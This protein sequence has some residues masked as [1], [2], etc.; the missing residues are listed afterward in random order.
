MCL[1][2]IRCLNELVGSDVHPGWLESCLGGRYID[3]SVSMTDET[4]YQA[5]IAAR[6]AEL[7]S[8]ITLHRFPHD[9][10]PCLVSNAGPQSDS[11]NTSMIG[12]CKASIYV[13]R[14]RRR[15]RTH[16]SLQPT[17]LNDTLTSYLAYLQIRQ[18][19]KVPVRRRI[20]R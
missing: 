1:Y 10:P 7:A 19:D 18:S 8:L 9:Y 17:L 4:K 5:C 3:T 2:C 13:A 15:Q 14:D 6:S 16:L 11:D 12:Q 20:L